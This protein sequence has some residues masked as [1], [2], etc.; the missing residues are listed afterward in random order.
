MSQ[1]SGVSYVSPAGYA[2]NAIDES[3]PMYIGKVKADG[4]WLIQRYNSVSGAMDYANRS[5]NSTILT[6]AEAWSARGSL[7]Y[8]GY[9]TLAG[10]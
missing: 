5:N 4:T 8:G 3:T 9:Q 10:V 6:Y 2:V 7:S 1:N